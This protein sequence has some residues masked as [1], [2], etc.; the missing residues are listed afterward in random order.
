MRIAIVNDMPLAVAAMQRTIAAT[1]HHTVAW[2]ACDGAEAVAACLRDRP[3]LIL[4]DLIMPGM[5]GVE[6]TRRIMAASPCPILVV[7]A[8]VEGNS[9]KVFEAMGAGAL[10]VVQTPTLAGTGAANGASAFLY[11]IDFTA[12]LIA[13][14]P[15]AAVSHPEPRARE[16]ARRLVA[17][18]ASAGGPAALVKILGAL[19][20][21]LPAAV[22]IVQHVDAQFAP[23]LASWLNDVSKLPVRIARDGDL[24]EEG[25]VLVAGTN[26]HLTLRPGGI[27]GY[28]VEPASCS[29]R[30]SVNVFFESILRHWRGEVLGV[31]LTGMGRDGAS[32]LKSLRAAGHHTIGQDRA[33]S[34][35]YGMP[36]AAAELGAVVEELPLEK[37]APAIVRHLSSKPPATSVA[38]TSTQAPVRL[39]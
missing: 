7:T 2:T 34:A 28:T 25:V 23:G 10:D 5:D 32:A 37:I 38:P 27:L 14:H 36:K 17:I 11:K 1:P 19:P 20:A 9:A 30:P 33:T 15:A 22:V 16:R 35:V 21:E 13:D 12:K 3:D 6:A 18:G 4:M 24:V 8:T 31:L 29:Y 26:D 39:T